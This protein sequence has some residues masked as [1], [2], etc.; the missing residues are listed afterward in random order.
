MIKAIAP[1]RCI[2]AACFPTPPGCSFTTVAVA[3]PELDAVQLLPHAY[4]LGQHPP[5]AE[6]AQLNQPVAQEPLSEA[7][8]AALPVG[9]AIVMLSLVII[10]VDAVAGQDVVSQFR[11]TRQHPPS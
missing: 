11:P 8:V 3:V 1:Q 10:A 7:A 5:P 2:L 6:A 9:T 4:P